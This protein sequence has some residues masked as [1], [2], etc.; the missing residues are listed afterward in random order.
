MRHL[1]FAMVLFLFAALPGLCA[2]GAP[3]TVDCLLVSV[4]P[5][6]ADPELAANPTPLQPG[7]RALHMVLTN[8]C[9]V[10]VTAFK[11]DISVTSPN[12][13]ERNPGVDML[14]RLALPPVAQ[15]RDKQIPWAGTEFPYDSSISA[16]PEGDPR[17]LELTVK[18]RALIFRDGTAAGDAS[19]VTS[20]QENR[21]K[22]VQQFTTELKMVNQIARLED[23]KAILKGDPDPSLEGAVRA[24]WLENKSNVGNDP[25]KWAAFI[26]SRTSN[27]RLLVEL[28][29]QYPELKMEDK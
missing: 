16:E 15:L 28:M 18:V 14:G 1:Q 29:S 19:W 24:F 22:L 25:A 13:Q 27:L 6:S 8:V 4:V 5:Q 26:T 11:L 23:A 17:P 7:S 21:R 9:S 3:K 20:V 12:P 2:P 10:D